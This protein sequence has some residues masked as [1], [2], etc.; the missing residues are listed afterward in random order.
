MKNTFDAILPCRMTSTRLYGKPLQYIDIKNKI[1]IIEYL[2]KYLKKCK[3]LDK[4]IL[5]IADTKGNDI[6]AEIA[7]KNNWEFIFGDEV[8]MLGRMIKAADHYGSKTII[9]GSTESPF[10]YN[11]N[12]DQVFLNHIEN[13][14]DIS[15]TDYLPDGAGYTIFK[16]D[17]LRLS[18]RDGNS[19]HRSELVSSYIFDNQDKFKINS[20]HPKEILK[21]SDI[22][23]TVDY[24][25]DLVFCRKIYTDLNGE[26]QLIKIS[27]IINYWDNNYEIRKSVE[28]IGVDWG[29]GRLWD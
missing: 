25:E 26:D 13:K 20:T 9:Q 16:T 12:I 4:I 23:I 1:T 8:D 17:A 15:K 27:N 21:R 28:E 2:V 18:H 3:Y 7:L 6:L 29:H 14:Y 5:A 11:D 10:M 24:P 22:R 19:Q